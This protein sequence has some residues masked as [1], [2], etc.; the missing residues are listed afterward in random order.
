MFK[1]NKKIEY[2]LMALKH[3]SDKDSG[4][5]TSVKELCDEYKMPFD[6]MSK[7]MQKMVSGK[8]L[9]SA[10]GAHGGYCIITDLADVSVLD[11]YEMI[12]GEKPIAKCI[13]DKKTECS[14]HD[15]CNVIQ[16][17]IKLNEQLRA[18]YNTINI[19]DLLAVDSITKEN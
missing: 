15:T 13:S 16:P 1:I 12:M 3:M 19:C 11:L 8:L 5:L 14:M 4:S 6:V 17:M 7:V 2:A 9:E 18:F 10:Q